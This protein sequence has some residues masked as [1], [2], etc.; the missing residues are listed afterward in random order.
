MDINCND[1]KL[2]SAFNDESSADRPDAMTEAE[3]EAAFKKMAADYLD[4]TEAQ[5]K[6]SLL[7]VTGLPG[8]GKSSF[9]AIMKTQPRT[10]NHIVINFDD[11]RVY[12]PR[13]AEHVRKD[14]VN[15]AARIDTAVERLIGELCAEA[16]RRKVNVILDD[17][18]MGA[19]MT[20]IVLSPFQANDYDIRAIVIAVP[21]AVARQSVHLRFEENL[22]AAQKGDPVIPRWVNA[23]EQDNAP[24]ALVETV[25]TLEETGLTG[26]L[27]IIDRHYTP[28]YSTNL[29]F[30]QEAAE[31]TI[32]MVHTRDLTK[33][34]VLQSQEQ[35]ERIAE[36]TKARTKQKKTPSAPSHQL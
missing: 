10:M 31:D 3:Y 16:A 18:A 30:P 28:L 12:H 15:A 14:A 36:L 4:G 32:K 26:H 17:A 13:Y 19:E 6:P 34:E 22:A 25:A 29:H 21:I 11:L 23:T 35:A 2:A 27:M 24:A 20:K 7:Y 1:K 9:V 5:M 33:N 8:S